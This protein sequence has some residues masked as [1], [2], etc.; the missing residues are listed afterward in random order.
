MSLKQ[1][2]TRIEL[3]VAFVSFIIAHW[4]WCALVSIS[5]NGR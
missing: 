3:N 4:C 2:Y 5:I 1:R